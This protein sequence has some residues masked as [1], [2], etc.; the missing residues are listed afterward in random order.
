MNSVAETRAID[1]GLKREFDKP[2]GRVAE[3]LRKPCGPLRTHRPPSLLDIAKVGLR[4]PE[5]SGEFCL[6]ELLTES[7]SLQVP[8]NRERSD[9][10]L[11]LGLGLHDDAYLH[12]WE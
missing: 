3:D 12:R 1:L 7:N 11:L 2:L 5:V 8:R 9:G 6:R 10:N 4:N